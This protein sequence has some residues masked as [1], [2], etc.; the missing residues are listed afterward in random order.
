VLARL[1]RAL[2]GPE[3]AGADGARPRARRREQ[4]AYFTPAP[5]VDLVV[6]EALAARLARQPPVWRED[7]APELLVLDPAAGDG[8]FL[9]A[10]A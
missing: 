10:A 5:L 8:R 3:Q 1:S 4:G 2:S 9:D 6:R 7:G